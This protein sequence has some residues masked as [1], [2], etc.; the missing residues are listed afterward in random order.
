ME[1]DIPKQYGT[2]EI[3]YMLGV[4][5][6]TVRKYA[7]A[8]ETAGYVIGRSEADRRI[9]TEKNVMAFNQLQA[10]RNHNALS[11][12]A[13]AMIV[14]AKDSDVAIFKH[15]GNRIEDLAIQEQYEKR[16]DVLES[17]MEKLVSLNAELVGRLD[18][19]QQWEEKRDRQIVEAL[20][21]LRET[22]MELAAAK[23]NKSWIQRIFKK[24]S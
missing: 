8:L 12:E 9:Y 4:E 14:A 19:R 5:P 15:D 6:V 13:A 22:R 18:Q 2:K 23:E 24:N 1:S 11:L 20:Q 7:V 3:A 16:F 17:K 10:L 21:E